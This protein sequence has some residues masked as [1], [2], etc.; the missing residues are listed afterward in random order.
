[1]K[2]MWVGGM[3]SGFYNVILSTISKMHLEITCEGR[4]TK[5]FNS[6]KKIIHAIP[7]KS[8]NN[9]NVRVPRLSRKFFNTIENLP[10]HKIKIQLKICGTMRV[11]LTKSSIKMSSCLPREFHRTKSRL[12][13]TTLF[14]FTQTKHLIHIKIDEYLIKSE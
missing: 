1:M 10:S 6:L 9:N 14:L 12:T 7:P 11:L 5:L 3:I 8:S 4:S 2:G 13:G